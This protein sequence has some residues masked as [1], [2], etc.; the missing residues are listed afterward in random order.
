MGRRG[1]GGSPLAGRRR[2]PREPR[3]HA[4]NSRPDPPASMQSGL[5]APPEPACRPRPCA[6]DLPSGAAI[7]RCALI[8][9]S[10]MGDRKRPDFAAAHAAIATSGE[11]SVRRRGDAR[12]VRILPADGRRWRSA[13]RPGDRQ[14]DRRATTDGPSYRLRFAVAL[15]VTVICGRHRRS[16]GSPDRRGVLPTVGTALH[17]TTRCRTALRLSAGRWP[18]KSCNV[19]ASS[20]RQGNA[21]P[22]DT[23]RRTGIPIGWERS[24]GPTMQPAGSSPKGPSTTDIRRRAAC[25][26]A[27]PSARRTLRSG[28]ARPPDHPASP[29]WRSEESP[30]RLI[31]PVDR[32]PTDL[33]RSAVIPKPVVSQRGPSGISLSSGATRPDRTNPGRLPGVR[34]PSRLAYGDRANSP[35]C[36]RRIGPMFLNI[37]RDRT[38]LRPHKSSPVSKP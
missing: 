13:P 16:I 30:R 27:W 2:P 21:V 25:A 33:R 20:F 8:R 10:G 19:A 37:L 35:R 28:P 14:D 1:S 36:L 34:P 29:R 4:E 9:V 23:G 18:A 24:C 26:A 32:V 6:R 11:R 17:G 7:C 22:R 3:G 38:P 5:A 31:P 12:G 15:S